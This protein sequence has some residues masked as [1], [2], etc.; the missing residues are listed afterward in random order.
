MYMQT[1]HLPQVV[2]VL[3]VLVV[4][5]QLRCLSSLVHSHQQAC[6]LAVL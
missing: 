3:V 2:L 4:L 6:Q 1:C 5:R